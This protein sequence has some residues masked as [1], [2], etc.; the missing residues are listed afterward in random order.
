M[1]RRDGETALRAAA[2]LV[3]LDPKDE[4]A[5]EVNKRFADHAE[6]AQRSP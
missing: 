1:A 6:L 2:E 5:A 3:T 4:V